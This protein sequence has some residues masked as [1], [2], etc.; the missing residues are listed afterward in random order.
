MF[1]IIETIATVVLLL[2]LMMFI[3]HVIRGDAVDWLTSKFQVVTI[4][5]LAGQSEQPT[6]TDNGAQT[7]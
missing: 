7:S 3:L 1:S 6:Q 4:D 5:N 2:L